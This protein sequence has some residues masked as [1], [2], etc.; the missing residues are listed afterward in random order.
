MLYDDLVRLN[1]LDP[2]QEAERDRLL[3]LLSAAD[4]AA[5]APVGLRK[6]WWGTEIER[7]WACL[8]EV[9]ERSVDL[10]EPPD[11]HTTATDASTRGS[12]HLPDRDPRLGHLKRLLEGVDPE[13]GPSG[14][15]IPALRSSTTQVLRRVHAV[16]DRANQEARYLR[17]RIILA[18][19]IGVIVGAFLVYLQSVITEPLVFS[20]SLTGRDPAWQH[21][22]AVMTL[23][24]LGA[25]L[26]AIPKMTQTPADFGPFNL[27]L[28][29]SILKIVVGP[30]TAVA[31][32][33]I[34]SDE[35]L[36][37]SLPDWPSVAL[38]AIAFGAGQ[39]VVTQYVDR[40]AAKV[41]TSAT[42]SDSRESTQG[43][44]HAD[45]PAPVD[46]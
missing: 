9:E 24:A 46:R 33:A 22:F 13:V 35:P 36:N 2:N 41:L 10:L 45:Q 11:L 30:L 26:I 31:G 29:Q 1:D 37:I 38:F 20:E 4:K 39:E 43:R 17:N 44:R 5:N 25:L 21:L 40:R 19:T 6:W 16:I 42:P 3:K 14:Q 15:Q 23:G 32:F 12:R 7:A 27:P 28:Q 18:S 34:L 8:R